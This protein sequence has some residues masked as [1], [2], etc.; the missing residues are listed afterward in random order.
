M[1]EHCLPFTA[2]DLSRLTACDSSRQVDAD[3]AALKGQVAQ[4]QQQA[5]AATDWTAVANLQA[6]Y[7]YYVDKMRW[8][9]AADLFAKDGTLEIAGRGLF[10]GQDRIRTYLQRSASW[11]TARC[12]ITC[13]CSR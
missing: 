10:V 9:D 1:R 6:T 7:G 2:A 4:L 8:D 13:S 11:N 3:L 5:Q 12:S